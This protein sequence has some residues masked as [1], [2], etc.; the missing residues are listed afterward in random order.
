[1][2]DKLDRLIKET[3]GMQL[4]T[5]EYLYSICLQIKTAL[6][7]TYI[8]YYYTILSTS[9]NLC[10]ALSKILLP[11]LLIR[12][13]EKCLLSRYPIKIWH[14]RLASTDYTIHIWYFLCYCK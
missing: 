6:Y 12:G 7:Y 8:V 5:S 1:M 11:T 10:C 4:N 2:V 14:Q 9:R 13:S 3:L